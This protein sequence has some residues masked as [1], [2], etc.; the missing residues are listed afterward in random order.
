M[1]PPRYAARTKE[2]CILF[3]IFLAYTQ[4]LGPSAFADSPA[5]IKSLAE[6][7]K[8]KKDGIN[9]PL[10]IDAEVSLLLTN[11][12]WRNAYVQDGKFRIPVALGDLPIHLLTKEDSGCRIRIKGT[13]D[14]EDHRVT[15]QSVTT[16][17]PDAT[18]ESRPICLSNETLDQHVGKY[19]TV[20][21]KVIEAIRL[22]LQDVLY[23]QTDCEPIAV[24]VNMRSPIS[25]I[26]RIVGRKITASGVLF[27]PENAETRQPY[28]RLTKRNQIKL[29]HIPRSPSEKPPSRDTLHVVQHGHVAFSDSLNTL[30]IA[31]H[32]KT[33]RVHCR[34]AHLISVGDVVKMEMLSSSQPDSFDFENVLLQREYIRPLKQAELTNVISAF[35]GDQLAAQVKIKAQILSSSISKRESELHNSKSQTLR[36]KL[37]GE[38]GDFQAIAPIKNE[39]NDFHLEDYAIGD[40]ITVKGIPV[41]DSIGGKTHHM[42]YASDL[43]DM[44]LHRRENQM[45]GR[46]A[47]L[48]VLA[49]FLWNNLLRRQVSSR[50]VS[51]NAVTSHLRTSFEAVGQGVLLNDQDGIISRANQ[52]FEAIFSIRPREGST[53]RGCLQEA[54]NLFEDKAQFGRFAN[55]AL[56][57]PSKDLNEEFALRDS[58]RVVRVSTRAIIDESGSNLGRLWLFDDITDQQRLEAELIHA[59]KMEAVGELSGGIAHDFNNLLSVVSSSLGAIEANSCCETG[60]I[61]AK[62]FESHTRLAELAVDRASELTQQLLDFSRRSQLHYE[63]V[64][65]NDVAQRAHEL[66]SHSMDI[67]IRLCLSDDAASKHAKMDIMRIEQVLFNL[68]INARD[69]LPDGCGHI[70]ISTDVVNTLTDDSLNTGFLSTHLQLER[71]AILIRVRDDGEGMS[72]ETRSR[73]FDPF[74][75]TKEPG[76][77]TGLGLSTALGIVDQHGGKIECHSELGVGTCFNMLFPICYEAASPAKI[78]KRPTPIDCEPRRILLVDDEDLVRQS[79]EALLVALGHTVVTASSGQFAIEMLQCDASFDAVLL[80]L[81]MPEMSGIETYKH[82]QNLWPELP[83][84]ICTGFL[85]DE[86]L[87]G[88]WTEIAEPTLL[89]KPFRANDLTAVLG[90]MTRAA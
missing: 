37:R 48:A 84:A 18:V 5:T 13:F 81:K 52:Q 17:D 56:K 76:V 7:A 54:C 85:V 89:P 69:A 15:L 43:D 50:T 63:I 66:L 2:A 58:K 60:L 38:D 11:P 27:A 53:V 14:P 51:L 62:K 8:A 68:C 78:E 77:G 32:G 42:L 61:E 90:E 24:R 57:D 74:F 71:Q 55:S 87:Q 22:P 88:D 34:F 46:Y 83:V 47:L 16:I 1:M 86:K 3:L 41:R 44:K 67:P 20:T 82:I 72:E 30:V 4:V 39:Q 73:I 33:F 49:L 12:T 36:L 70:E 29:V 26:Q 19:V 25:Q 40:R 10:S 79:G 21:G 65:V 35:E 75:T 64:A 59:Q 28:L 23:L 80:D 31:T 9:Q 6:L 45:Y